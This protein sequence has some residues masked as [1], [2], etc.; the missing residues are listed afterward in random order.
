MSHISYREK[1]NSTVINIGAVY[2]HTV[3]KDQNDIQIH[4]LLNLIKPSS[5]LILI[6]YS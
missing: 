5:T 3:I 2:T 4:T 1:T 6:N